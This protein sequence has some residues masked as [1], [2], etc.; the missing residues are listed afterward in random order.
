MHPG[1]YRVVFS[2]QAEFFGNQCRLVAD[3]SYLV[4]IGLVV[5][6]AD[7]RVLGNFWRLDRDVLRIENIQLV[8]EPIGQL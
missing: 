1:E 3:P 8:A 5:N 4:D 7:N 6:R 2:A